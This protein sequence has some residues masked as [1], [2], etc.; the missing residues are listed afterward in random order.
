[1][2]GKILIVQDNRL[3]NKMIKSRLD[4]NG[5]SADICETGEEGVEKAKTDN[6]QLVLLD[7]TL[8]GISGV[9]VCRFIKKEEKFKN[10]PIIFMSGEDEDKLI[11]IVKNEGADGYIS[12]ASGFEGKEFINTIKKFLEKE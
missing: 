12:L 11:N 9:E 5:F 6:Y 2:A 3:I 7:C 8:P 4:S 1:M 10:I